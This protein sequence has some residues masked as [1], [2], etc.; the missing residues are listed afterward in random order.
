[1]IL[2]CSYENFGNV[3]Q[4]TV[5]TAKL[6]GVLDPGSSQ[7]EEELIFSLTSL[8]NILECFSAVFYLT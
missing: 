5:T 4:V 3:L 7:G 2:N 1:V 6:F 8:G